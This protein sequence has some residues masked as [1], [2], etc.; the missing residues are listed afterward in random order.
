MAARNSPHIMLA[1]GLPSRFAREDQPQDGLDREQHVPDHRLAHDDHSDD[2]LFNAPHHEE[3]LSRVF[4]GLRNG[5]ETVARAV[6][7]LASC[8]QKMVRARD[9]S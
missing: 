9:E 1:I 4:H 8:L 5:D 2:D 6:L 7:T 3:L